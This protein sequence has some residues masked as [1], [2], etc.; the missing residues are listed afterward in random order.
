MPLDL[1]VHCKAD[2][3]SWI[4]KFGLVYR[5]QL[6]KVLKEGGIVK[7]MI[8]YWTWLVNGVGSTIF[9]TLMTLGFFISPYKAFVSIINLTGN[10]MA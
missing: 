4:M 7:C 2:W 6:Q 10:I 9:Q 5:D 1:K 8:R 3:N